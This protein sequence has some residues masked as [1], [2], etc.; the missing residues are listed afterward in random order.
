MAE[1]GV[2]FSF[3]PLNSY[4]VPF[5][6]CWTTIWLSLFQ[7]TPQ[8]RLPLIWNF[9][10]LWYTL[11]HLSKPEFCSK[12]FCIADS[13]KWEF[14]VWGRQKEVWVSPCRGRKRHESGDAVFQVCSGVSHLCLLCWYSH[15][16]APSPL[17]TEAQGDW[18][19][20]ALYGGRNKGNILSFWNIFV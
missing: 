11:Y 5:S 1:R 14:D 9:S 13:A 18:I 8:G 19:P 20:T 12:G 6:L 3:Y 2:K 16:S 7:L 15:H 10:H 4:L 17:C